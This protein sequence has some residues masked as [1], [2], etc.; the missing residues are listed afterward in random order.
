MRNVVHLASVDNLTVEGT[1]DGG[2]HAVEVVLDDINHRELPQGGHVQGL[3]KD[4]L[5]H[6]C[7][8]EI[9]QGHGVF[10][11]IAGGKGKTCGQRGMAS[12]DAV[13]SHKTTLGVKDVHGAAIPL[14]GTGAFAVEL[15]H[16]RAGFGAAYQRVGMVAVGGDDIVIRAGGKHRA[17]GHRFLANIEMAEA[18][19]FLLSVALGGS[20]FKTPTEQHRTVHLTQ[21]FRI[22][23][24][25]PST[26]AAS[27]LIS[28]HTD[29]H[30][31]SWEF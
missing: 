11:P 8:A 2:P 30:V 27:V 25:G 1:T 18:S 10:A 16:H 24:H 7:V 23:R 6:G 3:V 22:E 31:V 20:L 5:V 28:H 4:A 19:D 15:G 21:G 17:N 14:R 13:A 26:F 9:T 12:D 29:R